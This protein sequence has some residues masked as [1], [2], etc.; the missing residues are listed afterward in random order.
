[1]Q[2][3][4]T[5]T[6]FITISACLLVGVGLVAGQLQ[7][8]GATDG[9]VQL[10]TETPRRLDS[11]Q[12]VSSRSLQQPTLRKSRVALVQYGEEIANKLSD[13]TF[14]DYSSRQE[15]TGAT[16]APNSPLLSP[17][18]V[19]LPV[20]DSFICLAGSLDDDLSL[21]AASDSGF[22][23]VNI[24]FAPGNGPFVL[25]VRKDA[26]EIRDLDAIDFAADARPWETQQDIFSVQQKPQK[27]PEYIA[28]GSKQIKSNASNIEKKHGLGKLQPGVDLWFSPM[29]N[30]TAQQLARGVRIRKCLNFY[31]SRL[32]NTR[33]DSPWSI[34][35]HMIAWGSDAQIWVG[36][37][38]GRQV[39]AI[40]WLCGNGLCENERLL[41]LEDGSIQPRLGP[42]LQG[43]EGQFLAM[44][45]QARVQ[46]QQPIRIDGYDFTVQDLIDQEKRTCVANTELTF[47]LIG[48]VH[49]LGTE[50][51]WE[52]EDGQK[53]N[54]ERLI[55]E[56]IRQPI[57]G[58]TCGGTHRL[59]SLSYA[60]RRRMQEGLPIDGEFAR[61]EKYTAD[62]R[63]FAYQLRTPEGSFST[64]F[65]RSPRYEGD[66]NRKL[67]T[68]GHVLEWVIFSSDHEDLLDPRLTRALDLQTKWLIDNRY[69]DWDTGPLGHALRALAL[70]DERVYGGMPG[71]RNLQVAENPPW[72]APNP[73]KPKNR[74]KAA[75]A[76]HVPGTYVTPTPVEPVR[77]TQG[78]ARRGMN[79]LRRS[80]R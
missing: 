28:T 34:M 65:F 37:F 68:T 63:N 66:M 20:A 72:I 76:R 49:Y 23:S 42:G 64:D 57:N 54:I 3:K 48:L 30:A 59:M 12:I 46:E 40:G 62:Y 22:D 38:K 78:P 44:L 60:I 6:K 10:P 24:D 16:V 2:F 9:K 69:F 27:S 36:G 5:N 58:V 74:A 51:E 61:A 25:D 18:N 1:M 80:I 67:K 71:Q 13:I 32:L 79:F 41:T 17:P 56:E 29:S 21:S 70:Y 39:S 14:D 43:H 53:W 47:K 45:A 4:S 11:D 19:E 7:Q 50:A 31:Y 8:Y 55:Q 52:S 26:A 75:M 73:N 33:D 35:H 77:Q 15:S